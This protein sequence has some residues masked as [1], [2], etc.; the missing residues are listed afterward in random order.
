M[1]L[2]RGYE[3]SVRNVAR[4]QAAADGELDVL[5]ET[6]L[7]PFRLEP[8]DGYGRLSAIGLSAA[9]ADANRN[10]ADHQAPPGYGTAGLEQP[11]PSKMY[12]RGGMVSTEVSEVLWTAHFATT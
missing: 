4:A 7:P 9:A 10:L 8:L 11:T 5:E 12:T 3:A 2:C 6:P 1:G